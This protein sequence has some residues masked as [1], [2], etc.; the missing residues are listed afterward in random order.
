MEFYKNLNVEVLLNTNVMSI[1]FE[2]KIITLDTDPEKPRKY[3][4]LVLA[5]GSEKKKLQVPGSDLNGICYL[6]T[7]KDAYD[8]NMASFEQDPRIDKWAIIGSSFDCKLRF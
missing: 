5:M 1:D 4:Q 6:N 7:W 8:I 3:Q 2:K